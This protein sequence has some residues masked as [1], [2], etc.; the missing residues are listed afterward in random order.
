MGIQL[1]NN[2]VGYLATAINAS[3]TGAVLQT[4]NGASFPALGASDYF[5]ATL[6]S[7]GGTLEIV[8]VTAR[9]G[10]SL[11]IA[12]AQDSSTANSFAAGSR[13]A[14]RVNVAATTDFLQSGTGAVVRNFRSKLAETVSIKDFG[15][16]G[17]GTTDDTTA[18]QAAINSL[19]A[20]VVVFPAGTY[21]ISAK[22]ILKSNVSLTGLGATITY[23]VPYAD[24]TGMFDDNNSAVENITIQGFVFNGNGTWT[25]TPFANPYGGGNSVGFTNGQRGIALFNAASKKITIKNNTF[26]GLEQGFYSGTCKNIIITDNIFETI[27]T[28]AI[29][30]SC[31]FSTIANNVI[32]DVLGNQTDAGV[33]N[34]NQS[35]FAD[36][37]Y[38]YGAQ[39]VSV[40][41]NVIEDCIRIG[42]VLEGDG[43][44]LCS[45][46]SVTGNSLKNFNSCRGT[47]L[48]AAIWSEGGKTDYTCSA[49]GNVCDNTGAVAGTNNA[50]GI[51]GTR[52]TMT[53]NTI[54]AFHIGIQG[55]EVKVFSNTIK[56]NVEDGILIGEQTASQYSTIVGNYIEN[57]G[58][59]G[60]LCYRTK[61]IVNVFNNT[62]I[63]NGQITANPQNRSGLVIERYYNDQKIVI[64]GNTFVSSADQADV[65]GQLRAITGVNGGDFTRTTNFV[66]NNQFIYT[67]TFT[68]LYP[69]N[70][71]VSPC[72]FGYD[73]TSGTIFLFTL[74]PVN[75]NMDSKMRQPDGDGD[76]DGY[77]YMIGFASAIPVAG[78][79]RQG[80]FLLN[81]VQT[82]GQPFGWVCTTEGTPGT[83]RVISTVS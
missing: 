24:D 71:K 50:Y 32:R 44:T 72:S 49:T 9:S 37:I 31:Q 10:D 18:V 45:N 83:W 77:P 29:N 1:K 39:N 53:G 30:T 62:F 21:I 5:Y 58:A 51:L 4:G 43:V 70:L 40:T 47:E 8:K 12:R 81:S 23:T 60:M 15:A 52:L 79:F 33:T 48:N 57:S 67:G 6:E 76:S 73:N 46:I 25:S 26:T 65:T 35:V 66:R 7:T 3:D 38:L 13:F 2:A 36:G 28:A 11:T 42:V 56:S 63:D 14:L 22:I 64:A 68:T 34:I 80:D 78:T 54:T 41:G 20:G 74:M 82:S 55:E 69:D 17:N 59:A 27:G 19:T 16:T 75:G 61:G